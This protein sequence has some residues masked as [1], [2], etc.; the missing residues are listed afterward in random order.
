MVI[1]STSTHVSEQ[2]AHIIYIGDGYSTPKFKLKVSRSV[3]ACPTKVLVHNSNSFFM[4]III[5]FLCRLFLHLC[6]LHK[7]LCSLHRFFSWG[8][9]LHTPVTRV[10][11]SL[12]IPAVYSVF[13]IVNKTSPEPGART[14][15]DYEGFFFDKI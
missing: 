1:R 12:L 5:N 15:F 6:R 14:W 7:F 2:Y 11:L 9:T 10:Y 4:K 8:R 13:R 3:S